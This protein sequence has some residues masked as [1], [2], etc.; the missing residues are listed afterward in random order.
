[1]NNWTH[2]TYTSGANPYITTTEK[3]KR[4]LIRKYRRKGYIVT[5]IKYGFWIINDEEV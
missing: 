4:N 5:R 1:M 2:F 3:S